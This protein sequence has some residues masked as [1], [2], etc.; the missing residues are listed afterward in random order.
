MVGI[1]RD[2]NDTS[3]YRSRFSASGF[4]RRSEAYEE[5]F[6]NTLQSTLKD[7]ECKL[8]QMTRH[9]KGSDVVDGT[10]GG[11]LSC[12]TKIAAEDGGNKFVNF[13]WP[14]EGIQCHAY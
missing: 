9:K 10:I 4:D 2:E 11:I 13:F 8:I 1:R 7:G 5:P 14:E 3:R 12:T 6:I